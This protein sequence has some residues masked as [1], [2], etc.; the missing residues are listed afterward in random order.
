MERENY[1]KE[2]A[3][4]V[5]LLRP[6]ETLNFGNLKIA[7]ESENR[8]LLD[9]CTDYFTDYS[10]NRSP[11]SKDYTEWKVIDRPSKVITENSW[12]VD[13]EKRIVTLSGP[14]HDPRFAM[15]IVRSLC[16]LED[17]SHGGVMFKGAGLVNKNEKGVVLMG[18]K[19]AGKTSI[20]LSNML[21]NDKSSKFVSNS[22][23][24]LSLQGEHPVATGYPM[25]MGVRLNILESMQKLGNRNVEPLISELKQTMMPGDQNRYYLDPG[26]LRR[27]FQN[28]VQGTTNLDAIV[29][30]KSIPTR[31]SSTLKEIPQEDLEK[32]L[33]EYHSRYYNRDGSGWYNLFEVDKNRQ[34]STIRTVLEKCHLYELTYNISSHQKAIKLINEI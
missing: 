14:K 33:L 34:V 27:I 23:I 17:V 7:L 32:Y 9:F 18:A 28:R 22:Q 29:V 12:S 8:G 10:I 1:P 13:E 5:E 20:L 21:E 31:E 2:T 26:V 11:V 30:V 19:R 15:R 4:T 3:P 24:T 6:I 25:S 16:M